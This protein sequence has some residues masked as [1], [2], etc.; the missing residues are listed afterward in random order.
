MVNYANGIN[1]KSVQTKY[2]EILKCGIN[3]NFFIDWLQKNKNEKGYVNV[4]ILKRKAEGKYGETH[5]AVLNEYKKQDN[6][7]QV[8]HDDV[9]LSD[10]PF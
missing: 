3:V 6:N 9:N 10:I 1:I 2:G 8:K 7:K 5:Y 4:D